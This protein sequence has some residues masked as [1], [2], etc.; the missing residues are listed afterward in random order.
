M[1]PF[2]LRS[3]INVMSLIIFG[4]VAVSCVFAVFAYFLSINRRKR[5]KKVEETPAS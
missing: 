1:I 5:Q 2:E 3:F 4:G